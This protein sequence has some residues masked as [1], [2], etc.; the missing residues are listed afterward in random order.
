MI[1]AGETGPLGREG[2]STTRGRRTG[3]DSTR[4]YDA[5]VRSGQRRYLVGLTPPSGSHPL[6]DLLGA[7]V[8]DDTGTCLGT[9]ME[10]RGLPFEQTGLEVGRI[11]VTSIVFGP[12]RLGGELGY[13]TLTDQ[14]PWLLARFFGRWHRDDREATWTDIADVDWDDQQVTLRG[15][16]NWRHPHANSDPYL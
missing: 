16:R 9:V 12:R 4:R 10:L 1:G 2:S 14:G 7:A 15:D 6:S 3:G 5:Q 13:T 11:R 8:V